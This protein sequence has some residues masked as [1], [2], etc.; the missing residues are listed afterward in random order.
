MCSRRSPI[1][2]SPRNSGSPTAAADVS[3]TN[4]GFAGSDEEKM[5]TALD[6]TEGFAFVLAGAK[7]WL[8]HDIA[9]NLVRDR[10]PEG[11]PS[12]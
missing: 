10:F 5:K 1:P 3:I 4:S 6:S 12:A 2:R 9:L 8:E 11:L 7:A